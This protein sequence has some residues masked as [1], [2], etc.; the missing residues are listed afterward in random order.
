MV[1]SSGRHVARH[2]LSPSVSM[3]E[4]QHFIWIITEVLRPVRLLLILILILIL[5]VFLCPPNE[6]P[7]KYIEL[8]TVVASQQNPSAAKLCTTLMQVICEQD[9]SF[10]PSP[11]SS[12]I[13]R[14]V[15]AEIQEKLR[16][17]YHITPPVLVR[18]PFWSRAWRNTVL[19]G[20]LW[21]GLR[22]I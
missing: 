11:Y 16:G 17:V 22:L 3:S 9:A 13:S 21:G 10:K 20:L 18:F 2:F 7:G 1:E 4:L 8:N 19:T 12:R 14:S 15:S 6:F 5:I